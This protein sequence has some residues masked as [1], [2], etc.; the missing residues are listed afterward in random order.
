MHRTF[1]GVLL[2][3]AVAS[4]GFA[5]LQPGD[6]V[7]AC[8]PPGHGLYR[9]APSGT[10]QAILSSAA[11]LFPN[12]VSMWPDNR[13][14][15]VAIADPGSSYR[16]N[17]LLRVGPD[18]LNLTITSDESAA[19]PEVDTPV[20]SGAEWNVVVEPSLV[21]QAF[22]YWY[23]IVGGVVALV[24]V[25]LVIRMVRRRRRSAEDDID[26]EEDEELDDEDED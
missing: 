13:D 25:V 11:H 19:D 8:M 24:V 18:G 6:L 10:T 12:A 1:L 23:L 3:V 7:V 15:A 20:R 5:Q 16:S 21:S 2:L 14:L 17:P 26:E 9:V 22:E 4:T